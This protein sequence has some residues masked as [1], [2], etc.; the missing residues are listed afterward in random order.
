M[1]H[2]NILSATRAPWLAIDP[3][4]I[5]GEPDY[6][7]GALLRNP[8]PQLL[9]MPHPGRVT[10]RRV[11]QL[12]EAL[13]FDR[14][15]VRGWGLAQAVLSAWWCIEDSGYGWEPAIACAELLAAVKA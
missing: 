9:N 13:G 3:K 2:E 11:D 8:L 12:A 1:H 10:A 4:G 14:A 5:V 15:R 6:E 7:V